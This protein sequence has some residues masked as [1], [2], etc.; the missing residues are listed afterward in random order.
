ML[1]TCTNVVKKNIHELVGMGIHWG[2][3]QKFKFAMLTNGTCIIA[4]T[5][6]ENETH[7]SLWNYERPDLVIIN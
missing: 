3:F 6:Q 5:V 1:Q 2:F 4:E 7:K